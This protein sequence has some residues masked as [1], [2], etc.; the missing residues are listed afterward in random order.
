MAEC[1][2]FGIPD[3][4]FGEVPAAVFH[5]KAGKTLSPEALRE[6]L[7]SR[8]AAFKVPQVEHIRLSQ[9]P[10]PRLGTQKIDKRTVRATYSAEMTGA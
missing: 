9:N 6:F 2:V 1:A 4:H 7:L 3:D 5:L 10:L 8:I